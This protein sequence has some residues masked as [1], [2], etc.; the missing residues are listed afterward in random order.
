MALASRKLISSWGSRNQASFSLLFH[1]L[2]LSLFSSESNLY[3]KKI[4]EEEYWLL[5]ILSPKVASLAFLFMF[6]W[7]ELVSWLQLIVRKVEKWSS[8]ER[9]KNRS[10]D[11]LEA[12]ANRCSLTC[13]ISCSWYWQ[14]WGLKRIYWILIQKICIL[15]TLLHFVFSGGFHMFN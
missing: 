2:L 8:Q 3:L 13:T 7:K 9:G 12:C 1:H 4:M 14:K 6:Q 15:N 10:S 11:Q 5:R